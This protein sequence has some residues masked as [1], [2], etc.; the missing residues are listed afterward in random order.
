MIQN[1]KVPQIIKALENQN[2]GIKLLIKDTNVLKQL[3][4]YYATGIYA[5]SSNENRPEGEILTPH[6]TIPTTVTQVI[7]R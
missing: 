4:T 2:F 7:Q 5:C 6:S 1:K 3:D